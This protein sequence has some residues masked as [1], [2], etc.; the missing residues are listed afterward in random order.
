MRGKYGTFVAVPS[1]KQP[2]S[3]GLQIVR[4]RPA[5]GARQLKPVEKFRLVGRRAQKQTD[6][7]P[8]AP[9]IAHAQAWR[10]ITSVCLYQP[11]LL[12]QARCG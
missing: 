10:I 11:G 9:S 3:D 6:F 1:P 12:Y 7:L 8:M 2:L 5:G 4:R